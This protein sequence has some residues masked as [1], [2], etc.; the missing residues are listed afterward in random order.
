MRPQ[1]LDLHVVPE[2]EKDKHTQSAVCF[3][4]PSCRVDAET[5]TMIWVHKVMYP[6]D[7]MEGFFINQ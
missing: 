3:C 1:P 5:G 4:E 7:L 6:E 2:T